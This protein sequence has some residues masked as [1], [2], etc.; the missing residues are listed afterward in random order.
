MNLEIRGVH[1][2]VSETTHDFIEK[3]LHRLD[4]AKEYIVDLTVT[5]NK[6]SHGYKVDGKAHFRWGVVVVVEEEAHELYGAI[7]IMIDKLE[8]SVRKEKKKKID[9]KVPHKAGSRPKEILA[10]EEQ[11]DFSDEDLDFPADEQEPEED[12]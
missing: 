1:Y 2:H 7:E 4:F 9:K 10:E 8:K 5:I 6:E 3:K 12:N 11:R